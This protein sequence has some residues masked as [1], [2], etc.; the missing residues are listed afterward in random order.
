LFRSIGRRYNPGVADVLTEASVVARRLG[1]NDNRYPKRVGWVQREHRPSPHFI[2]FDEDANYAGRAKHVMLAVGHGP[3]SFPPV[4]ARA[5]EDPQ[6]RERIVQAYEPKAYSSEG[7]YVVIGAGIASVNEWANAIDAGGKVIS[8][9]R[10]PTPD[11]QDLN[12]P[13]CLFE[14]RGIDLYAGLP[15]DQRIA[16]LG[17][18][19]KGTSPRRRGWADR[20]RLAASQGRFEQLIGEIDSIDPGPA[21]LRIRVSSRHGPDP[22]DLDVTGIIAGTGFEKSVLAIPLMRRLIEHYGVPVDR[23]RLQ[24]DTNCGMPGLDMPESRLGVMGILANSVIPHGD[25]IAGL[26]YIGRRFAADCARAERIPP[27][28]FSRRF[29]LQRSLASETAGVIRT[30]RPAEQLA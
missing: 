21:G 29:A 28:P 6:L 19:L 11:E 2:L 13:R 30:L 18:I 9:L 3:L 12:T 4:M 17:K 15:F 16:Y 7:R 24:L 8:L 26:K 10:N 1:W 14:A 25:T 20:V 23:G 22:G 27:L 5:R